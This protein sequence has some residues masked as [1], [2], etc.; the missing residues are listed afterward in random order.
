MTEWNKYVPLPHE[1]IKGKAAQHSNDN[2]HR[3]HTSSPMESRNK[4]EDCTMDSIGP[5]TL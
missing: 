4:G 1:G 2:I 5:W 3:I